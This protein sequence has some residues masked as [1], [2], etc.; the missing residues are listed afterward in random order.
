M[1]VSKASKSSDDCS[2]VK[3]SISLPKYV[4]ELIDSEAAVL[5]V[6]RS[7]YIKFAVLDKIETDRMRKDLPGTLSQVSNLLYMLK[8]IQDTHKSMN[9]NQEK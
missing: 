5:G 2:S 4:L 9:P 8:D 3:L 6:P 7:T 1:I